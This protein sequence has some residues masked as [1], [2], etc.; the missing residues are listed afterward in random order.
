MAY[1][2]ANWGE[3]PYLQTK[4][5]TVTPSANWSGAETN[6]ATI[7]PD[8]GYDAMEKV[9]VK[10]P[11]LRDYTLM[12]VSQAETPS[13]VYNGNT[14]QSN[15]AKMLRVAPTK[16]GMSYTNSYLEV[17]ASSAMGNATAADVAEGKTFSSGNGI[18]LTGTGQMGEDLR[19]D[20]LIKGFEIY[21]PRYVYDGNTRVS[22]DKILLK[23]APGVNGTAH[24]KNDENYKTLYLD[25]NSYLGTAT[26]D[27]VLNTCSFS[28]QDGICLSGGMIERSA[29]SET[30][31]AA[32]TY[33]KGYYPNDWTVTPGSTPTV[34]TEYVFQDYLDGTSPLLPDSASTRVLIREYPILPETGKD[35]LDRIIIHVSDT[36]IGHDIK[37]GHFYFYD[38]NLTWEDSYFFS[39]TD[40]NAG[41]VKPIASLAGSV[42]SNARLGWN[43]NSPSVDKC[44]FKLGIYLARSNYMTS[45]TLYGVNIYVYLRYSR[46]P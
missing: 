10:V 4:N 20:S 21:K 13:T 9:N 11:M 8:S 24:T 27:K 12:T 26:K 44:N 41:H 22:N 17:P 32:K 19:E 2:S 5:T 43:I 16:D 42:T 36:K 30:I 25:A 29:S 31:S 15:S 37:G 33:S 40:A 7:T 23:I 18:A 46:T 35:M 3:E 38:N 14:A 39:R 34:K 6:A 28:S 45:S 1:V